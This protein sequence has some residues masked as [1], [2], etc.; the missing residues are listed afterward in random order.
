MN[1]EQLYAA[2]AGAAK[3]ANP[4]THTLFAAAARTGAAVV[5][6]TAFEV[7]GRKN[8]AIHYNLTAAAA[9]AGDTLDVK[10]QMSLDGT[11]WYDLIHFTQSLG[12]GGAKSFLFTTT[13]AAM[14]TAALDVSAALG[15]ATGRQT[16]TVGYYIRGTYTLVDGGAHNQSFTFSLT[17]TGF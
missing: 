10:A 11:V 4:V 1:A 16:T 7:G 13:F 9:V 12:N 15:S 8:W 3:A 17:A 6:G 14:T 2:M 5:N